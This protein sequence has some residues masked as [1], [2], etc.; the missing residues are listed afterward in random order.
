MSVLL[1]SIRLL[2]FAS[3]KP[4][5]SFHTQIWKKAPYNWFKIFPPYFQ[6]QI[7]LWRH[8]YGQRSIETGRFHFF[9]WPQIRLASCWHFQRSPKISCFFVDLQ[10]WFNKTLSSYRF[11]VRIIIH[12]IHFYEIIK[13]HRKKVAYTLAK[14]FSLQAHADLLR[15][16]FLP[17]EPKCKCAPI[18]DVEDWGHSHYLL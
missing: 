4:F 10:R 16:D 3:Y 9:L 13:T 11:T 14:I 15:F 18:K 8:F 1:K 7:W 12:P 17:N 2:G 6:K 5:I